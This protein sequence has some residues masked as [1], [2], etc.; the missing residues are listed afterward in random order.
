MAFATG[1]A[2]RQQER[3]LAQASGAPARETRTH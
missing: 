2:A 1:K 3:Q